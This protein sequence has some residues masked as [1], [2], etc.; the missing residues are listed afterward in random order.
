MKFLMIEIWKDIKGVEGKY[1]ISS[2]GRVMSIKR[3]GTRG[4]ILNIHKSINGYLRVCLWIDD[5]VKTLSLSR[6]IAQAFIPNPENKPEVNH[7]NGIKTDNRIENLEWCTRDENQKHAY[8]IGLRSHYGESNPNRKLNEQQVKI[9][10]DEISYGASPQ[11]LALR[12]NVTTTSI[13]QIKNRK[14]WKHI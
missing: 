13:G 10:R 4:G 12:F 6:L 11:Q 14:T 8:K 5:G 3:K 7:I 2:L 9:I 1:E